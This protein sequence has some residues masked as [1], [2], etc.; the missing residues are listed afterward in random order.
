MKYSM[1][2]SDPIEH[3]KSVA[4]QYFKDV[5]DGK[6]FDLMDE[7]FTTDVMMHRPEGELS[8]LGRIKEIFKSL[9]SK[10]KMKTTIHDMIASGDR[11]VVRLSHEQ[12][13]APRRTPE[14]SFGHS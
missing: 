4:L 5:L 1:P 12:V 14:K 7:L 3:N 8:D 11:V 6:K 13:C 9:L 10:S 2:F